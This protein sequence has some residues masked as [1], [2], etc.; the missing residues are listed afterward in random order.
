[1][2]WEEFFAAGQRGKIRHG[3]KWASGRAVTI[4]AVRWTLRGNG[5]RRPGVWDM[6]GGRNHVFAVFF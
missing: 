3:E 6:R 1:M 5:E 4:Q 2:E